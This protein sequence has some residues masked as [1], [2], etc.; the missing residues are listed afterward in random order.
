MAGAVGGGISALA[1]LGPVGAS[2]T[3]ALTT[4]VALGVPMLI[5]RALM[6]PTGRAWLTKEL[7]RE[8]NRL[9]PAVLGIGSQEARE[10]I[11]GEAPA[12]TA[13]TTAPS[14]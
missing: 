7:A 12:A 3:G 1:G 2:A 11:I 5:S 10:T 14:L 13:E 4:G 8:G 9:H 6:S